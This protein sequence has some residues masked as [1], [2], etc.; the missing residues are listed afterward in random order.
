M[1]LIGP[2]IGAVSGLFGGAV[3]GVLTAGSI[4]RASQRSREQ[5]DAERRVL[6]VVRTYRANLQWDA[7]LLHR[8]D[9]YPESYASIGG[10]EHLAVQL[11]RELPLLTPRV[12]RRIE[13][14]LEPLFGVLVLTLARQRAFVD[15]AQLDL[16]AES[17]RRTLT[18]LRIVRGDPDEDGALRE[19]LRDQND[20][21][22]MERGHARVIEILDAIRDDLVP[23]R[24]RRA[25]RDED[26][27]ADAAVRR[28]EL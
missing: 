18:M 14:R 5:L 10:Q 28:A 17:R 24:Y 23:R 8:L 25:L 4:A 12:A 19:L 6:A 13:P 16:D 21:P 15:E 11:L 26:A 27:R 20:R 1:E 22:R 9:H 3:G 2:V 7:A